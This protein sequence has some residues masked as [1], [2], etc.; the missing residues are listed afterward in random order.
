MLSSNGSSPLPAGRT[1]SPGRRKWQR[2]RRNKRG[3][4]SLVI[5]SVLF[6]LSLCAEVISN[7]KPFLVVYQDAYY[8]PLFRAY[9]E[10]TFGG[11]FETE[12]DYRDPFFT[13]LLEEEGN[14][15]YFPL[16]R[17]YFDT[18]NFELDV[19]VPSPPTRENVLG[20]D[21]RGRDVF[22]RLLYGFRLSIF[23]GLALT[24]VGTVI[25]ILCGAVQWYF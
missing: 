3:F 9:P 13:E 6:V 17:H 12:T 2:F 8:F 5:F 4:Y 20:T 16:N 23:F 25:G 24:G 19:P 1:V 18:I 22:A 10:T 14:R 7:D 15:A 11:I 21:D